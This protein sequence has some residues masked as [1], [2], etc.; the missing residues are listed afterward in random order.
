MPINI[1]LG[2]N[3]MHS[4]T[5]LATCNLNTVVQDL[6]Q[7]NNNNITINIQRD[8]FAV[9]IDGLMEGFTPLITS[10]LYT[11][12]FVPVAV[13]LRGNRRWELLLLYPIT[14]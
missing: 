2:D 11:V 10:N 3:N 6:D 14:L 13:Q 1:M 4:G 5:I 7:R 8:R 9:A 12:H